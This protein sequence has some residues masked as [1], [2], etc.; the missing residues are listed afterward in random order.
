MPKRIGLMGCGTVAGYG[1]L[2][3]IK[4]NP[5]FDLVSLFDPVE[6]NLLEKQQKFEVPNAFTDTEAFFDSGIEAVI[7]TS[8]APCHL[9]NLIDAAHHGKHVLCE[10]PLTLTE[11]DSQT[12][13]DTAKQAGI[14]LFTGFDY[15]FSPAAQR[16]RQLVLDRAVGD[17]L[18]LRL[19]YIWN[20]HGKYEEG[21]DGNPVEQARR[22]DRMH[23]G[24]P[25]VD[26]GVHQIDLAR[27]WTG[28]EVV[29]WTAAGAWVDEYEAPD[30]IYLHMDHQNG[31]HS[32]VEISFSYCHTAAEP[33]NYFTYQLIGT[34][35]VIRYELGESLLEVRNTQGT[36]RLDFAPVKNFDGMYAAFAKALD[37]G[38]SDE[39]P[40]GEDGLAAT[41]LARAST[42]HLITERIR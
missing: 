10:K 36:Q 42:E 13:I 27:Y 4:A 8:P 23:E 14:M 24:G 12:M 11:A 7:I 5:E 9:Q 40:S 41:K 33:I 34:E 38:G 2:P 16:I 26:C 15:R 22:A 28:S 21:P 25:L 17:V 31:A 3:A 35:G 29:R 1:H 18:S 39:L 32:L 20:C 30:H 6:D 37:S 19:I